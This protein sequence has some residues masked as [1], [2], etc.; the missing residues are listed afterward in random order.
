MYV[1]DLGMRNLGKVNSYRGSAR[2]RSSANGIVDAGSFVKQLQKALEG[3]D[4]TAESK[5]VSDTNSKKSC[6]EQCD[7]NSRLITQMMTKSL[8]MQSGLG[9]LGLLGY[10]SAG[11]GNLAAYRSMMGLFSGVTL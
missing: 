10:S 1:N 9:G 8:Y 2:S 11:T 4:A 5:E 6:C 7:L 3:R